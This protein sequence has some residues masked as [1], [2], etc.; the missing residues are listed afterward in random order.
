MMDKLTAKLNYDASPLLTAH[1]EDALKIFTR[2][3]FT[4]PQ[5][6]HNTL[7]NRFPVIL[8]RAHFPLTEHIYACDLA[9][10][11][12]TRLLKKPVMIRNRTNARQDELQQ[13]AEFDA[14]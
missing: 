5:V 13:V 3:G 9:V 12:L 11:H 1:R 6:A 4:R 7:T 10:R 2:F 8:M 14:F